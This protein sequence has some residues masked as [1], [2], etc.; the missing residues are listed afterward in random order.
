MLVRQA[1]FQAKSDCR[2]G[3]GAWSEDVSTFYE[4]RMNRIKLK[5]GFN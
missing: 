3:G 1:L 2:S 4:D 5:G